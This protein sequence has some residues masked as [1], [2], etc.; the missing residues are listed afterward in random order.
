[1]FSAAVSLAPSTARSPEQLL[2]DPSTYLDIV[3]PHRMCS[4]TRILSSSRGVNAAFAAEPAIAH[5]THRHRP[6][7]VEVVG[8]SQVSRQESGAQL[9]SD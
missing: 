4:C 8:L 5:E 6:R 9:G 2:L 3:Q 1:M 7:V